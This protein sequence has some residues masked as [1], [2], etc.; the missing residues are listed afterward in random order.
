MQEMQLSQQ[1]E[2]IGKQILRE[3][4]ARVGFLNDAGKFS[5]RIIVCGVVIS[6]ILEGMCQT[7]DDIDL[8]SLILRRMN[9]YEK[10]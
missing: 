2:L 6:A 9:H 8:Q 7:A 5:G 3:I 10:T 4:R 1:Q